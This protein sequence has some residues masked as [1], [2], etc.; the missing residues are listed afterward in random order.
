MSQSILVTGASGQY[1]RRVLHHLLATHGIPASRIVAGTRDPGKLKD[2][3]AQGVDVRAL[4]FEQPETFAT[5]FAGVGRALLVST[6]AVDRPGRRLAQHRQAIEGLTAAGVQHV[7]YTSAPRPEGAPL[8]IAPDHEGTEQ[9]LAASSLP[10]W[11]VLRHHWYFENLF[12]FLPPAIASGQWFA[13]DGGQGS[14]DIARDDLALAGATVLSGDETAKKVYTLSGAEALTKASI[15]AAVG[16]AIGKPIQVVQI[17]LEDLVQ[18]MVQAGLP[19]PV[20]R[21]MASFDTNTAEGRVAEVTDDFRRITG[22]APQ[23]FEDW[24]MANTEALAAL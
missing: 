2:V 10:G 17:P 24:V 11:T 6:D 13:A 4:D 8:L 14:A 5:A 21:V 9:A 15:A 23:S 16:A 12:L 1:G 22:R 3:A 19:E 18:G 20:A 7:I